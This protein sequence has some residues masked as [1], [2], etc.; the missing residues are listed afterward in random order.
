[1]SVGA[2]ERARDRLLAADAAEAPVATICEEAVHAF[3]E[4]AGF[5]RCA[6]LTTDPDTLLP[7]GGIVEGFSPD[8]CAPY[9]DN[10]LLD[11]DFNKF[12]D[13]A[14]AVEPIATLHEAVDGDLARSPRYR[15][16]YAGIGGGDELRVVFRSGSTCLATGAFLRPERDGPFTAEEIADVRALAPPATTVLR[17]ALGR[18]YGA[19]STQAPVVIMLD[20][21]GE[22][23]AMTE[24]GRRVLEDLRTSGVDEPGLPGLVQVA[25]RRARWSRTATSLTTGVRGQSGRW[26]RMHVAPIE[27]EVGAVAV[28]V[29]PA[30]PDDLVHILLE[31]YGLTGRETEIALL[32]CRGFSNKDIAAELIISAHTVRDHVKAIFEKSGVTSRGELVAQLLSNRILDGLHHTVTHLS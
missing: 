17:R 13:L 30:R 10:E 19:T 20:A 32:L 11:A 31:S 26:L 2:V 8:A 28:T 29:E 18:L 27:G 6:L 4:V 14:R 5:T 3:H 23:T 12:A 25:A 24:G 7:S 21:L 16:L 9:W 22:V 15:N 1:V